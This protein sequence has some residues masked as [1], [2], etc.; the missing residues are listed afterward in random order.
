MIFAAKREPR[1]WRLV[2]GKFGLRSDMSDEEFADWVGGH[3]LN[4]D[5]F[6]NGLELIIWFIETYRFRSLSK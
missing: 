1:V 2:S 4:T 6:Y 5:K 3:T